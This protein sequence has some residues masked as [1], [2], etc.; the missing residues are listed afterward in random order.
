MNQGVL[1]AYYSLIDELEKSDAHLIAT[2]SKRPS[3]ADWNFYEK[4]HAGLIRGNINKNE[5]VGVLLDMVSTTRERL[6]L[7]MS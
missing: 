7:K 5:H 3:T 1:S 6:P 2:V 4:L